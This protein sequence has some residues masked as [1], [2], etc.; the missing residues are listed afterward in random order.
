[1]NLAELP[2]ATELT[3]AGLSP[4][5]SDPLL[6]LFRDGYTRLGSGTAS[7]RLDAGVAYLGDAATLQTV[8]I[9]AG[10]LQLDFDRRRFDTNLSVR[11]PGAS[12]PLSASGT[13]DAQGLLRGTAGNM[14]VLG[15]LSNDNTQAGYLFDHTLDNGDTLRGA[16][17]WRQP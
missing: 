12:L 6:V 8:P 10:S 11:L 14:Q 3:A 9:S 1:V 16:T 2:T 4:L 5:F 13:L 15:G 17:Q 7:F